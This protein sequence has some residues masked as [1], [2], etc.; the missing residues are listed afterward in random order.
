MQ[1]LRVLGLVVSLL[2]LANLPARGAVFDCD[3]TGVSSA[4]ATPGG[5]HT[6]SCA[7]PTTV[8]FTSAPFLFASVI[9]DGENELTLSGGDTLQL[10]SVPSGFTL[11]LRNLVLRDGS[12]TPS[13][14]GCIIVAAGGSL[15]L[16][17]S[18]VTDCHAQNGGAI[19]SEG[20]VTLTDSVVSNSTSG[21]TG[22]GIHS[23]GFSG[24]ASASLSVSGSRI[25]GNRG[26]LGAGI[27]I[28]RGSFSMTDSEI[29]GNEGEIGG[30]LSL[31]GS[32]PIVV[33][34]ST[35]SGNTATHS[36]SRGGGLFISTAAQVPI[37]NCTISGNA[38]GGISALN[39]QVLLE[40]S[41]IAGN[42]APSA[43]A[44]YRRFD[45][46]ATLTLRNNVIQGTCTAGS[47]TSQ[48]GS[49]ESPGNTCGLDHASDQVNVSAAALHLGALGD[50]GGRTETMPLLLPSAAIDAGVSCPPPAADQRGVARPQGAGCDSG[51]FEVGFSV[52]ALP[53]LGV[54]S[55]ALA[56][57]SAGSVL[58]A[59]A[60]A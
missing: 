52:P 4:L 6:F 31:S 24:P 41:T 58:R 9:L 51:A 57:A 5:P 56:L 17:D 28:T 30:G 26:P 25:L 3:E 34:G 14:G 12:A 47:H 20:S 23:G 44:L 33:A 42:T 54:A 53:W 32:G 37:R 16:T 29:A 8:T 55:L 21:F 43:T 7:G 15:V 13:N 27:A 60:R 22:G 35:I 36:A 10:F 1:T 18:T 46:A 2:T 39:G 38:G 49:I 11:E 40:H 48:G 59:R 50:H 45:S 19:Y